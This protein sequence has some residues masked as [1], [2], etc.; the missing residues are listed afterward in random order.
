MGTEG[1]L[2]VEPTSGVAVRAQARD[3]SFLN[4]EP[5]VARG[6]VISAVAGI[7]GLL[8]AFGVIDNDQKEVL[9]Q[10]A[11]TIAFAALTIVPII[12]AIWTRIAVYSPRTTARIAVLNADASASA[13]REWGAPTSAAPTMLTPP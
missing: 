12:Q 8:V 3:N 10:N 13:T 5:A 2:M 9:S 11:G 7:G 6:A 4:T 1:I